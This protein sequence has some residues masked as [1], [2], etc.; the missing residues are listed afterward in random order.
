MIALMDTE[1]QLATT[2]APSS[3][4]GS[5]WKAA[6]KAVTISG[7]VLTLLGYGFNGLFAYSH[8]PFHPP[9]SWLAASMICVLVGIACLSIGQVGWALL[10]GRLGRGRITAFGFAFPIAL[11][12]IGYCSADGDPHG[13]FS[14]FYLP[15]FP[16]ILVAFILVWIW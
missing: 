14:I 5:V 3:D 2:N 8:T 13:S 11:A 4:S 6:W 7:G 1:H 16:L 9:V 12:F 15:L 10:L